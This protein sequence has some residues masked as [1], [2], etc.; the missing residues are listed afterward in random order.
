MN[1]KM[2]QEI[3]SI[4]TDSW[5]ENRIEAREEFVTTTDKIGQGQN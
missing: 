1:P 2:D 4:V 3:R 5:E